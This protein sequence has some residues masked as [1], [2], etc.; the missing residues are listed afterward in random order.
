MATTV[1]LLS[2]DSSL[3]K[4]TSASVGIS[5]ASSG[6]E[7]AS[8]NSTLSVIPTEF[9]TNLRYVLRVA[10]SGTGDVTIILDQQLLRL[11]ENG[12]TLSF[13]AKLKP[14]SECTVTA[15]LVVDGEA[16]LDPHQQTLSGGLYGSIQSN[17][18]V[19]PVGNNARSIS[20]SITVSGHDGG[21][22]YL[23]YPNLINDRAFYNNQYIALARNFMPDFYWEIDSAQSQPT[24][25][26]HRL[27]DILTSASNEVMTE[28]RDIYPFERSEITNAIELAEPIVNSALVNPAFVK[29]KYVNWLSQF[30]GSSVRKN[31]AKADG[32]KFFTTYA[33]ERNFIEW[34]LLNSYYGR[35]A[36]TRN[37]LLNS[38]RQVLLYTKDDTDSTRSVSITPNYD[39]DVWSFLVRTLENETPDASAGQP[40]HLVLAAMEPARPMGFKIYHETIDEFYV[41]LDDIAYGRLSEIRLGV[42]TAPTDAPDSITVPYV[43]SNS[44]SL[45]FLP[46]SVPGGGDGGG[47]ISNYQY[48]LSTD[49]STYLPYVALSPPKGSPPIAIT[50]LSSSQ[51][52]YVKLK[53]VNEAG[54]SS[55][56]STPVTFT[57]SA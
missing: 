45:S 32:S 16:A 35:G 4:Q 3:L 23:T 12:E 11:S 56:E 26:F 2:P 29:D 43:T 38:A 1:N 33:D 21:N 19:V 7:W 25:P 44:A 20:A 42:V 8:T 39:G 52:Y 37:A 24:A 27:L 10:P 55:V 30:T 54:V 40:S 51:S 57:T 50:G 17:T 41:T 15:L 22:M 31:I 28:Y 53:A 5:I 46:L 13:N 47:I 36:G 49:G 34:Q 14:S 48:A 9:V 18:V 6:S